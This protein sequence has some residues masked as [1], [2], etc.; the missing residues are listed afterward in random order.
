MTQ[1]KDVM[2]PCGPIADPKAAD[3]ARNFLSDAAARDGWT[4]LLDAAWPVLAPI[5]GASPYLTSL[6]RRSPARLQ[7]CSSSS[8]GL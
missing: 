7:W 8:S 4:P 6:A 1:L 3:R 5:F 2:R